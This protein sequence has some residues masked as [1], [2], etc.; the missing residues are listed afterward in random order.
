MNPYFSHDIFTRE[1]LKIKR[2][3]NKYKMTGYGVFWAV[4]EFLHNNANRLSLDELSII[5]HEIGVETEIVE[6]IIKDFKLFSVKKNVV[7]S[8]RVAKNLKLQKEKSKIAKVSAMHRWKEFPAN[9]NAL[10]THSER[11]AIKESKEKEKNKIKEKEIDESKESKVN[12]EEFQPVQRD[13]FEGAQVADTTEGKFYSNSVF[14]TSA[15]YGSLA[16]QYGQSLTDT[17]I[18][19][20]AYNI[21][22]G[23]E[24]AFNAEEP[25]AH[26]YRLLRY[27]QQKLLTIQEYQAKAAGN[28]TGSKTRSSSSDTTLNTSSKTR[29]NSTGYAAGSKAAKQPTEEKPECEALRHIREIKEQG[30]VPPPPEF[31]EAGERLRQKIN[32]RRMPDAPKWL[33]DKMKE[34]ER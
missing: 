25:K 19:E 13:I 6:S 22:K 3:I 4:V 18:S 7:S 28:K 5:A 31:Y 1:N 11:N 10:R 14:L 20:L 8:K 30:G 2:L 27:A 24:Q 34:N 23:K 26:F 15:Q 21:S 16:A 9:A 29:S 32:E 12:Q 17:V 33:L